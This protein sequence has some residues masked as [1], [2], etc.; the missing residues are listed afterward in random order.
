MTDWT[1]IVRRHGDLVWRTAYRLLGDTADASDCY[2][3]TFLE[4]IRLARRETV[5]DWPALLRHLATARALDLLRSRYRRR[6][7]SEPAVEVS[8]LM[9]RE[10]DPSRHAEASE[11]A[12]RLRLALAEL[13]PRQAEVFCL[14]RLD[15]MSY[16]EAADRLELDSNGVGALLHRARKQL[17]RRLASLRPG[18]DVEARG[19]S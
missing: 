5:G 6:D 7:R 16:A 8:E 14:C 17:R 18:V 3:K 2:Q 15:G 11:L 1:E 10:P 9:D 4:A 13:P 12:E 19:E